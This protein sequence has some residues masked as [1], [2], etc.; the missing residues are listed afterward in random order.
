[1]GK[2]VGVGVNVR[3]GVDVNVLV[4]TDVEVLVGTGVFVSVAVGN[5]VEVLVGRCPLVLVGVNRPSACTTE[6]AVNAFM[7]KASTSV[8][9]TIPD[10]TEY[11]LFFFITDL[12]VI[13]M[14][15]ILLLHILPQ[16]L[17]LRASSSFWWFLLTRHYAPD[18][19]F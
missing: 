8:E 3:V 12:F 14:T 4:G 17:K 11:D 5:G 10:S 6:G 13:I 18:P 19:I 1:M 16:L 9:R 7:R 2:A 15:N